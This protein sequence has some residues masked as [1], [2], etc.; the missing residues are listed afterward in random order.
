MK[1]KLGMTEK[2]TLD[3]MGKPFRINQR[4]SETFKDTVK[5]YIFKYDNPVAST[6]IFVYID[7]KAD[8]VISVICDDKKSLP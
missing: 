6:G 1:L 2:K 3:I 7:P 8:S 5:F 4:Y